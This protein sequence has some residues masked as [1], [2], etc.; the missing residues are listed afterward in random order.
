MQIFKLEWKM[1]IKNLLKYGKESLLVFIG[2]KFLF[3][4][5]RD[6]T[7]IQSINDSSTLLSIE[8]TSYYITKTVEGMPLEDE[9]NIKEFIKNQPW[10]DIIPWQDIARKIIEE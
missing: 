7:K 3:N 6:I 2:S 9:N 1:E 4:K 5:A 8:T 10:E